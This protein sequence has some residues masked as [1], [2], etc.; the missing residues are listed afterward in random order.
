VDL[1]NDGVHPNEL[2]QKVIAMEVV[3]GIKSLWNV[4]S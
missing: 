1:T 2:G 3:E 4:M